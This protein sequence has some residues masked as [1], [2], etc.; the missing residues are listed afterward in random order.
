MSTRH[1]TLYPGEQPADAN[2]VLFPQQNLIVSFPTRAD[3]QA[4]VENAAA[5]IVDVVPLYGPEAKHGA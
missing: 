2:A 5:A 3:A 4:A 1:V